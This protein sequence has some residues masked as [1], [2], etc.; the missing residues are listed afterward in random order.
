MRALT[1][2][3]GGG[4]GGHPGVPCGGGRRGGGWLGGR[5]GVGSRTVQPRWLWVALSKATAGF[6]GGGGAGD[7]ARER[8]T[9][10]AERQRG[11]GV[12]G[13]VRERVRES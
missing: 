6:H 5:R 4:R 13:G 2:G 9:G 3:G 11:P 12:S 8:L 10:A 1:V 7:V